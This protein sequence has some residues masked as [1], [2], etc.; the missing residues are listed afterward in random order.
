[1]NVPE[2]LKWVCAAASCQNFREFPQ[3]LLAEAEFT[4]Q[5]C[6]LIIERKYK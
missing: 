2:A 4:A 6:S 1:M 3:H 5:P